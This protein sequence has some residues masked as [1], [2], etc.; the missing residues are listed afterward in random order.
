MNEKKETLP[1]IRETGT[2]AG[3][4]QRERERGRDGHG[5]GPDECRLMLRVCYFPVTELLDM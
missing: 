4:P 3:P 5:G 1:P 2:A